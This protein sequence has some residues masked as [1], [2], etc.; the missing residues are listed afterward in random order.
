MSMSATD[1]ADLAFGKDEVISRKELKPFTRRTDRHGLTYLAVHMS[2]L[3]A[4]GV[5]LYLSLGTW[6][7]VPA[8]LLHAFVMTNIYT[9]V[10]DCSH[11]TV[12]RT[13]WLNESVYR[14]LSLIY[15]WTP[16]YYRYRH[17]MHHTYTQVRGKERD[18]DIILSDPHWI[19]GYLYY[20]TTIPYWKRQFTWLGSHALGIKEPA[21]HYFIPD[22][23]WPRIFREA[24]YTWARLCRH[25][26]C[27]DLFRL[28]GAGDLLVAAPLHW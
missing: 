28:L 22:D 11:G 20:A 2:A 23:E 17:A 9:P 16:L 5:L 10:H 13:R 24:R 19:S 12:F 26:R 1:S 18:P 15:I 7:V 21:D 8:M 3:V 27:R 25:C 14:F 6:W 4:S